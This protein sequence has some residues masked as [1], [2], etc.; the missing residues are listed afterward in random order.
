MLKKRL[1]IV[2]IIHFLSLLQCSNVRFHMEASMRRTIYYSLFVILLLSGIIA[3]SSSATNNFSTAT[4][5]PF[6]V[7][8]YEGVAPLSVFF[9]AGFNPSPSTKRGFHD[10]EYSWNFGD[11]TAG[12]WGTS[13]KS[14]NEAKGPVTAHVFEPRSEDYVD[15]EV[16]YTVTL[17]IKDPSGIAI[18]KRRFDIT[19]TDPNTVYSGTN[20]TCISTD[21]DF[22][23]CP[24]GAT[25][26]TTSDISNLSAYSG[27]GKRTLFHRGSSWNIS[28]NIVW[29]SGASTDDPKTIGAYGTCANPDELGICSNAPHITIT[30]NTATSFIE[31]TYK[32]NYRIMDVHVSATSTTYHD[33][34]MI[35]GKNSIKD[36]LVLRVKGETLGLGFETAKYRKNDTDYPDKI[37]IVSSHF[38][39]TWRQPIY[40]GAERLA[41]MGNKSVDTEESHSLRVWQ[42]YLGV[43]AHNIVYG[44][45]LL[46]NQGKHALK[47]HGPNDGT[48]DAIGVTSIGTYAETG[49]GGMRNRTEFNVISNNIFGTSGPWTVSLGPQSSNWDE[50]ITDL[51][52]ENNRIIA[53]YGT[54]S[55]CS[56]LVQVGV[57]AEGRY[58]TFR[59]NNFDGTGGFAGYKGLQITQRGIEPAPEYNQVYNNTVYRVDAE[60]SDSTGIFIGSTATNT[61]ITNNYVSFPNVTGTKEAVVDSSG[62]ST[63]INNIYT[64][65]PEFTDPNNADPL[66]RDFQLK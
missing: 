2:H 48:T 26:V 14:K 10:Y 24:S 9:N 54:P 49:S 3:T 8:R 12:N 17:T 32:N 47:L 31:L 36:I 16:K 37:S 1:L 22:V 41:I 62:V 56:S 65:T 25:L 19:V 18:E 51:I 52:F 64:D 30:T 40:V 11:S 58:M 35:S 15:G 28:T 39:N 60:S 59:N 43:I 63:L 46:N 61:T 13:G 4:S 33:T 7:S 38:F 29:G 27:A 44:S 55:C 50:R 57:M 21:N 23:G 42:S 20:T 5:I 45:S 6:E 53:D 66:L 34:N